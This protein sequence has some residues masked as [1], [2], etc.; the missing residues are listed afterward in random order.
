MPDGEQRSEL[1]PVA[2]KMFT[3]AE[4]DTKSFN[5][6]ERSFVAW[7]SKPVV[8]RDDELIQAGAWDLKN[9]RKNPILFWAHDYTKF[10]VGKAMWVK[11]DAEGL[12]FKPSFASTAAGQE[13]YQ[14]YKEDVLKA[15]SVGF[16]PREGVK[17]KKEGDPSHTYTN[18]ELLEISCVG[19][20]SCPDALVAAYEEGK[21]KTKGLQ[22]A[23]KYVIDAADA[24]EPIED[25][26]EAEDDIPYKES[27]T[28]QVDGHEVT[29]EWDDDSRAVLLDR[30][31]VLEQ[32]YDALAYSD[33]DTEE[34][35]EEPEPPEPT[36]EEIEQRAARQRK[37]AECAKLAGMIAD[38]TA[39]IKYQR[40]E[41]A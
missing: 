19:V 33:D 26:E 10:P 6:D 40:G 36:A 39:E 1:M 5:D 11:E 8:D 4:I 14:L 38:L 30:I 7:A 21:I 20:P 9:Y 16:L 25:A 28:I 31:E 18:V 24:V 41:S 3:T 17:G 13:L 34:V 22:Q 12:K 23:V 35:I 37:Q 32:R 29:G 27:E 2:D 15:F